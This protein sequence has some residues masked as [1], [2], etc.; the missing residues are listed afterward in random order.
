MPGQLVTHLVPDST[1]RNVSL[2]K[3]T[4]QALVRA[5]LSSEHCNE[6]VVPVA[7]EHFVA[8]DAS[9]QSA[10]SDCFEHGDKDVNV[11]GE[12]QPMV[13]RQICRNIAQNVEGV[14]GFETDPVAQTKMADNRFLIG[15][16]LG[17]HNS[18]KPKSHGDRVGKLEPSRS[19]RCGTEN[20]RRVPA[21]G[22]CNTTRLVLQGLSY[23]SLQ[24]H[25]RC[26]PTAKRIRHR[27]VESEDDTAANLEHVES[28]SQRNGCHA[29]N[30]AISW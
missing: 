27:L 9:H 18:G 17:R 3:A 24:G 16:L 10:T 14:T 22:E 1:R 30:L 28:A 26:E 4:H 19:S 8:P 21:A 11:A 13:Y 29:S 5:T 25:P 20:S 7:V 23:S 6:R 12:H 15:R 2:G